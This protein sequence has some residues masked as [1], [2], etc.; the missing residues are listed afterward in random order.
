MLQSLLQRSK[1]KLH[2]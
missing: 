1:P 2:S